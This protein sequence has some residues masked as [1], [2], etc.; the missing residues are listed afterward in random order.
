MLVIDP[1]ECID[2]TLCEPEC[3]ANAI[4]SEDEVPVGMENFIQLNAELSKIWPTLIEVKDAFLEADL[5]NGVQKK[6]NSVT[7]T[8]ST[9]TD[10]FELRTLAFRLNDVITDQEY[11]AGLTDPV[12]SVRGAALFRKDHTPDQ[13]QLDRAVQDINEDVRKGC[14]D[15]HY[16]RMTEAQIEK[17]FRDESPKVRKALAA[18]P[19]FEPSPSQLG[20]GLKDQI[21]SIRMQYILKSDGKLTAPQIEECLADDE[22]EVQRYITGQAWFRPTQEQL[23]SLLEHVD[24]L[25]GIN[26]VTSCA[27]TINKEQRAKILGHKHPAVRAE[28]WKQTWFTPT[29]NEIEQ[30]LSD[31]Y[32][33]VRELVIRHK[34]FRPNTCQ[35]IRFV[36]SEHH[37]EKLAIL[38]KMSPALFMEAICHAKSQVR[39]SAA[40]YYLDTSDGEIPAEISDRL[41]NDRS[42]QVRSI[43]ASH[44]NIHLAPSDVEGLLSDSSPSVRQSVASREDFDPTDAQLIRGAHDDSKA[45]RAEFR[46]FASRLSSSELETFHHSFER[47]L[48]VIS[49]DPCSDEIGKIILALRECETW[50]SQKHELSDE[51]N[52]LVRNH[53]YLIYKTD[54]R[55][56]FSRSRTG[57]SFVCVVPNDQKGAL[58]VLRGKRVRMVSL[59]TGRYSSAWMAAGEFSD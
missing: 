15:A 29:P 23:D 24:P 31:V 53:G 30:G 10:T 16:S 3:P 39:L 11:E 35:F 33:A 49:E 7:D 6:L 28:I 52:R 36:Q 57:E 8:I 44:P 41:L 56:Y 55:S 42:A 50:T 32:G 47:K 51:L 38:K 59:G 18:S 46:R 12:P 54:Q 2:C 4:F 48:P 37:T 9:A 34:A 45:V 27:G 19:D 17:L 25:V 58:S 20:S 22:I 5:M 13:L 1:D 40:S 14:I 21:A 43:A 26:G